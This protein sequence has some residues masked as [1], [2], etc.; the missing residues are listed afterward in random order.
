ML[1]QPYLFFDGRCEEALDFYRQ[2]IG[3][4]VTMLMRNKESPEPP[5]PGMLAPGSEEKVM[6]AAFTVGESLVMASDG[7][8]RGEPVFKGFTL[9][10]QAADEAEARR[11]FDA[12]AAGGSVTMPLG[13]TFWS[14]AFG[15]LTDRFGIGWMVQVPQAM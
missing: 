9:S 8:A 13:K 14:P 2:A 10:L 11:L 7:F 1:I 15:M 3:A 5:P 4:K 12:L 6:H